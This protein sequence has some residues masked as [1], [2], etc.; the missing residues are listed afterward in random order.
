M[1]SIAT[2]IGS[3]IIT[4]IITSL[5]VIFL[6]PFKHWVYSTQKE[7]CAFEKKD[8]GNPGLKEIVITKKFNKT[9]HIDCYWFNKREEKTV[10]GITYLHCQYGN[11]SKLQGGEAIVKCPFVN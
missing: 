8:T 3:I 1:I 9:T 4:A 11:K 7:R 6:T 10:S 5:V 2:Y